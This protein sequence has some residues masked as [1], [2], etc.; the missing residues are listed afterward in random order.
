M[1]R[2]QRTSYIYRLFLYWEYQLGILP[3]GTDYKPTSPFMRKNCESWD[4][5]T[6]R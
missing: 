1:C 3:K 4:E 6:P 5:S 2:L